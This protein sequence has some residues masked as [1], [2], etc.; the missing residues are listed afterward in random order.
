MSET[1]ESSIDSARREL[2][3]LMLRT[4][5]SVKIFEARVGRLRLRL[6]LFVFVGL[7]VPIFV[8]SLLV[9]A[10][11]IETPTPVLLGIWI[12]LGTQAVL[13][14]WSIID[15]WE[16]K[17]AFAQEYSIANLRLFREAETVRNSTL[18]AAEM[19]ARLED[20]KSREEPQIAKDE[21]QTIADYE[22]RYG[23]RAAH[24]QLKFKC[25]TCQVV[26]KALDPKDYSCETCGKFA[27][28]RL[29]I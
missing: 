3:G 4:W 6:R 14:L 7:A 18:E 15:R 8:G 19:M 20:L 28:W 21:S 22:R 5:A 24:Y 1:P 12:L 17:L 25:D 11:A 10:G 2:T 9:A 16:E 29:K 23:H 27:Y 26:P 13:S